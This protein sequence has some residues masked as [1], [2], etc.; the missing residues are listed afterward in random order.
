MHRICK[1]GVA[2]AREL[3]AFE[4]RCRRCRLAGLGLL[5]AASP[6][7]AQFGVAWDRV[8]RIVVI[9]S[10]SSDERL[11]LVDEAIAYW[12]ARLEQAG[13]AFRLGP[14]QRLLQEPPD[15][16][17]Q[18]E[19]QLILHGLAVS[20]NVPAALTALPGDLRI[21][22]G[23]APFVSHV[24][25]FDKRN[26]RTVAIRPANI[27]PMSEPNVAR[28]V[29]AHEIGHAV[30]LAHNSDPSALMCGRPASCRP[31]DFQS[32]QAHLFPLLSGELTELARMYPPDWRAKGQ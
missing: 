13:S 28:N 18:Q 16:A 14:A 9:A 19:S 23:N 21:V 20:S 32:S 3:F 31:S 11:A 30:G 8:P 2:I 1:L 26:T 24:G 4:T 15:A 22:L 12:N 6:A 5:F 29:I 27:P 25:P 17:L 10:S 7:F